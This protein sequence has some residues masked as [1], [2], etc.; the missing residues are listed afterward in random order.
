MPDSLPTL[1]MTIVCL[2]IAVVGIIIGVLFLLHLQGLLK[3]IAPVNRRM[4]PGMVW[5]LFIPLF[6]IVWI[7]IVVDR[8]A[9][10]IGAEYT[11]RGLLIEPKPT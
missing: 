6:N 4:E 7:F 3:A 5:L 11:S 10:S 2:T 8:I 9:Q 1:L